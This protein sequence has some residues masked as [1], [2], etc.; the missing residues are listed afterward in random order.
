[1][2]SNV[3][4]SINMFVITKTGFGKKILFPSHTINK[5]WSNCFDH[6]ANNSFDRRSTILI[7]NLK[8]VKKLAN[9]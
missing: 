9:G 5:I 8:F 6:F 4:Y 2:I 7:S 1:M 3:F